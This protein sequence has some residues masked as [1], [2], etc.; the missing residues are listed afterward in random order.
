[1]F[2]HGVDLLVHLQLAEVP[3]AHGLAVQD[4]GE[5][6]VEAAHVQAWLQFVGGDGRSG[7]ARPLHRLVRVVV[8]QAL[9]GRHHH[10]LRGGGHALQ[11]ALL[12]LL[13][14]GGDE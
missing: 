2:D 4:L 14:V 1:V 6:L 8:T 12:A 13:I 3:R 10:V 9:K 5:H 11:D 7:G